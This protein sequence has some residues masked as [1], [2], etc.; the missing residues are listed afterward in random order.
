MRVHAEYYRNS[1]NSSPPTDDELANVFYVL[2]KAYSK[3]KYVLPENYMSYQRF[4]QVL[5]RLDRSSSPGWPFSNE[6]TTI[7]DFL[8]FDGL[9]FCDQAVQ[10]L[11]FHVQELIQGNVSEVVFSV[12]I[13]DEPHKPSK[14]ESGRYRLILASPL[15]F[16]VL[17]HM[18]FDYQNDAEVQN[19]LYLPSQQGISLVHGGWKQYLKLWES[20]G[21][22]V[23]LDK[24]AWDWTVPWW[25]L[26]IDLEHRAQC[27]V[28][29]NKSEWYTLASRMYLMAFG[30]PILLMPNGDQWKQQYPGIMKSG[31]V[32]TIATNS[33]MQIVDHILVTRRASLPLY[34][35]PVACGDDTLQCDEQVNIEHYRALGAII[36]SASAGLE[37][38]GHEFGW[39]GPQPLYLEKHLFGA[40]YVSEN[41]EL[42]VQYLTSMLAMYAHSPHF[43]LWMRVV[44]NLGVQTQVMS[45]RY[46]QYFYDF[47]EG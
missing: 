11:W 42:M 31:L 16:Q 15:P 30:N 7:G 39:S 47:S 26:R 35:L 4:Y 1:I 12:F 43:N 21:Y 32:N 44:E 37:F 9:F 29:G 40:R 6:A 46:Y 38:V 19:S 23:G 45:Q 27:I 22:N 13:K 8:K 18:L 34:P 10:R 25:K 3:V 2:E 28:G 41:K 24:T 5:Y 36:K 14:I 17:W 20:R 33:K